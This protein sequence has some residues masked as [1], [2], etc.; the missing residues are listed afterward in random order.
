MTKLVYADIVVGNARI[1]NSFVQSF[2]FR[3]AICFYYHDY[4]SVSSIYQTLQIFRCRRHYHHHFLFLLP[5]YSPSFIFLFSK[6]MLFPTLILQAVKS[7]VRNLGLHFCVSISVGI[8]AVE[9][10]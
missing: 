6:L 1:N 8:F 10:K 5:S 7:H 9:P 4:R 3:V 2:I